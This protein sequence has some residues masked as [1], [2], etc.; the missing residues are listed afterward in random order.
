LIKDKDT[1]L[2]CKLMVLLKLEKKAKQWY[3]R[4]LPRGYFARCVAER[5]I[6]ATAD[7]MGGKLQKEVNALEVAMFQLS[8]Q[9][10]GVPRLFLQAHD[11]TKEQDGDE[12]KRGQGAFDTDDVVLVGTITTTPPGTRK[13]AAGRSEPEV[14][15]IL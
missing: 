9:Q 3:G 10:G 5:L 7:S 2:K 15:E 14:L 1:Q 11:D 13:T 8:E 12:Q 6:Q 4:V